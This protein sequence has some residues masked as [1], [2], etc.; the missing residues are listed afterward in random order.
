MERDERG[1]AA[2]GQGDA[3][4]PVTGYVPS[5]DVVR[6]I[7]Q[8]ASG[9]RVVLDRWQRHS[10]L[11]EYP[12]DDVIGLAMDA[13][14]R[15]ERA[16]NPRRQRWRVRQTVRLNFQVWPPWVR[17]GLRWSRDL[18][19]GILERHEL[20][21]MADATREDFL[22]RLEDPS[23]RLETISITGEELQALDAILEYLPNLDSL[24]DPPEH[25]VKVAATAVREPERPSLDWILLSKRELNQAL[26][27]SP[28]HKT[29]I[30][31]SVESGVIEFRPARLPI[32]HW[33]Y[34]AKWKTVEGE[35]KAR[36]KIAEIRSQR[37]RPHLASRELSTE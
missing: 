35:R 28:S 9:V 36:E 2:N 30:D 15:L 26:D 16:V 3:T 1:Q 25:P 6:E 17:V 5:K 29:R 4:T 24:P 37:R 8:S 12:Q 23:S 20:Q 27:A 11:S 34:E 33:K 22:L 13:L 7:V 10:A 14:F 32:G 18:T 21:W 31:E 19:A